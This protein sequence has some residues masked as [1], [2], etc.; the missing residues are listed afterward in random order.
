MGSCD[1]SCPGGPQALITEAPGAPPARTLP[2]QDMW[3]CQNSLFT[4]G[5]VAGCL[6][7]VVPP[8]TQELSLCS[9]TLASYIRQFNAP[10]ESRPGHYPGLDTPRASLRILYMPFC[11]RAAEGMSTPSPGTNGPSPIAPLHVFMTPTPDPSL[12]L[13][14]PN[15]N[16]TQSSPPPAGL[17]VRRKR[18]SRACLRCRTRKVRCDVAQHGTPCTNCRLDSQTCLLSQRSR[19]LPVRQSS[20]HLDIRLFN[21]SGNPHP[22]GLSLAQPRGGLATSVAPARPAPDVAMSGAQQDDHTRERQPQLEAPL[23]Q[24]ETHPESLMQQA[25]AER[26]RP[27]DADIFASSDFL[28]DGEIHGPEPSVAHS[29]TMDSDAAPNNHVPVT[30]YAF[31]D[32][33]FMHDLQSDDFDYLRQCGCF[34]L[35]DRQYL[36]E[37][38]QAYFLYVHHGLPLLDE[39]EFWATY[40]MSGFA[41][42]STSHISL[43]LLQ[44][45]LLVASSVSLLHQPLSIISLVH[46]GIQ[47]VPGRNLGGLSANLA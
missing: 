12:D 44:A 37:L 31:L 2:Y 13:A 18:A 45:M 43:I 3:L 33:D 9:P 16:V 17:A 20:G 4:S 29:N 34:Y 15:D 46:L 11:V 6:R 5:G 47:G 41:G 36:K 19:P 8:H 42:R 21:Q 1:G 40:L 24:R 27:G 30:S 7:C 26:D 10:L 32:L 25:A 35:P 28:D 14:R 23:P 39:E 38:V 22:Y